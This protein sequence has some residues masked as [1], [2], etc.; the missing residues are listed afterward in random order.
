[1]LVITI[2]IFDIPVEGSL[3]LYAG[4]M[5]VYLLAEMGVGI[6][7]S[8]LSRTQAQALPTILLLVTTSAILAGFFTP[9]NLMPPIAQWVS[10]LVPL[11]YFVA[12]TR[13]LFAKGQAMVEIVGQ[14]RTDNVL[15]LRFSE[16]PA[17]EPHQV[18]LV[19][20][21]DF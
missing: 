3:P 15:S 10:A 1:M 16:P 2:R 8:T 12:I 4:L 20:L 14:H 7:I 18:G 13:D 17:V 19:L 9:V 21:N 5:F 11:R 6:F